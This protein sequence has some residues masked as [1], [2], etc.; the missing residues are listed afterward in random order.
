MKP[1]VAQEIVV[2]N[3]QPDSWQS[4]N[5]IKHK[6]S[7]LNV[8]LCNRREILMKLCLFQE[9]KNDVD[10]EDQINYEVDASDRFF[11]NIILVEFYKFKTVVTLAKDQDV[12]RLKQTEY[13]KE[14]RGEI[15]YLIEGF[16]R[17]NV[18]P[19]GV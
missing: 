15:P 13:D 5:N 9:V 4:S 6:S 19:F 14:C 18:I 17:V 12:G 11:A 16:F 1:I 3:I 2:I 7:I 10:Q 8:V